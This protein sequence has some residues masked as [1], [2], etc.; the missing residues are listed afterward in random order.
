MSDRMHAA[1][2]AAVIGGGLLLNVLLMVLL[3]AA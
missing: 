2:I 3:D 1:F